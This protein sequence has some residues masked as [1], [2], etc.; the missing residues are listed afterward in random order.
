MTRVAGAL[1]DYRQRIAEGPD[2]L[3]RARFGVVIARGRVAEW[4]ARFPRH[5]YHAPL[6]V[7]PTAQVVDLARGIARGLVAEH[8]ILVRTL[9]Q[10]ALE[11]EA[12]PDRPDRLEEIQSIGW[13]DLDA[14]EKASCP[15]LLV[16]GDDTALLEQGFEALGK[17]LESD[18][19]V[20]VILLDGRGRLAAGTEPA[21]VA[22]AH[23]SAFVLAGSP[24][25]PDHLSRGMAD[26]LAWPGPAL[27][28]LHAPSPERHGFAVDATLERARLAV[29]GRAHPLL[30]YDPGAEGLF[31]LRASLEGNPEP[32]EPWGGAS[33]AEWAAGEARFSQHFEVLEGDGDLPL[34]DWLALAEAERGGRVPFIEIGEQRLAVSDPM[35]KAA[36][37]RLAV[38]NT[39]REL[40]G[41]SSPFT[42]KVREALAA[43]LQGD[44]E[45]EIASLESEHAARLAEAQASADQ[46]ALDRLTDRLL[47]LSG[48]DA[49]RPARSNG[50]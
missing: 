34:D 11:A 20:K 43:E 25:C 49:S 24:A 32:E 37:E 27:I 22:M 10:A 1:D 48:F 28:H 5:P 35:A 4:A 12:P 15:P 33:F 6:A 36:G 40:T 7:A 14:E 9:R 44:R 26:A 47:T 45:A 38:W 21:L 39:L 50:G 3:G 46:Q 13:E 8:L 30:R 42:E 16:L 2:G 23:R 17:L 18:L 41:E 29:E 19:P 31:G